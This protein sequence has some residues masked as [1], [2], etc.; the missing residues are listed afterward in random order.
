MPNPSPK[1]KIKDLIEVPAVKT[2]IE[3]ATVRDAA[4]E[5]VSQLIQLIESFVVTADIEKCLCTVLDQIASASPLSKRS[6]LGRG[7][8]GEGGGMGFFLTGSY[9]SGKSHLLSVLS[10]LLQHSWAW[11]SIVAQSESLRDYEARLRER[12]FLVVQIP[13]LEYRQVDTLEDIVWHS[14]E[15]T[16]ASP[17]YGLLTSLAP[18]SATLDLFA[19]YVLPAHRAEIG[20]FL[21]VRYQY[22]GK[23][24]ALRDESPQ[25]ALQYAQEYLRTAGQSVPF[26]LTLD[27]QAAWDKLTKILADYDFDGLA[28][29][30]D[31]LSEFL[32]SKAD[33]RALNEDTRTL[34]FLGERATHF[35]V[36]IVA[37]L[38]EA[39]EKT[40]DISQTTFNKIKDRYP[41]RLE[42]STRHLR[43]L[44]DRRLILKKGE[45]AIQSIRAVYR[46]L[47][48]C[49]Q[50]IQI[51]EEAFIQIYP[52][53]PET[54]ELL[55]VNSRF[56]SQR[57]GVIDFIHCQ[58]RG[59][60]S[61]QT[62]GMLELDADALLTPDK[63]FDH[64]ALRMREQV[65]L[66]PYYD[67]YTTYFDRHIPRIFEDESDRLLA[68]KLIKILILLK[69][70]PIEEKR[71]VRELADMVLFRAIELGGDLN[72]EYIES[73]LARLHAEVGYL[74]VTS[75]LSPTAG[76]GGRGGEAFSDVYELDLE[77]NLIDQVRVKVRDI[78]QGLSENDGRILN[79]VFERIVDGAIPFAHLNGVYSERKNIHWENTLRQG[80]VKLCNLLELSEDEL[81]GTL[82]NLRQTE[83]DFVLY[84]G[85]PFRVNEQREHFQLLIEKVSDRFAHGIICWLP[86][87]IGTAGREGEAPAEQTESLQLLKTFHAYVQLAKDVRNSQANIPTSLS[88][89]N[90]PAPFPTREGG[91]LP[92]PRRGGAGG[93]VGLE[94]VGTSEMQAHLDEWI[95]QHEPQMRTLIEESYFSGKVY[96]AS[97][98]LR[99]DLS[100]WRFLPFNTILERVIQKPLRDLYSQHIAPQ[101]GLDSWRVVSELVDDFVRPGELPRTDGAHQS[102]QNLIESIG[103]PFNLVRKRRKSYQ[104]EIDPSTPVLAQILEPFSDGETLPPSPP[105]R[106]G[107]ERGGAL[108]DYEPLYWQLRKSEF[109]L[110]SPLFDLLLFALIRQGYLIP[111]KSGERVPLS[112]LKL[113]LNRC[114]ELMGKGELISDEY[115]WQLGEVS[116]TLLREEISSYDLSRQEALWNN[117]CKV[118]EQLSRDLTAG[119][120][121]L[122]QLSD[123]LVPTLCVGITADGELTEVLENISRVQRVIA[124]IKP[125]FNSKEGL[126]HFLGA[127]SGWAERKRSGGAEGEAPAEPISTSEGLTDLISK[128]EA[129]K[130]FV[131]TDSER[132]VEIHNYLSSPH[133][134]IPNEP[135]YENLR[136]LK[137]AVDSQLQLNK[138]LIFGGGASEIIEAFQLFRD[139]YAEHYFAEHSRANRVDVAALEQIRLTAGYS[140]LRKLEQIRWLSLPMDCR[141]IDAHIARE[142]GR[143]CNRLSRDDLNRMPACV[144]GFQLGEKVQPLPPPQLLEAIHHSIQGALAILQ[145]SP[146]RERLETYLAQLA[147][148]VERAASPLDNELADR[149]TQGGMAPIEGLIALMV[150]TS[151][152]LETSEVLT[153]AELDR[154]L[155]SETMAH[156]NKALEGGIKMVRRN[157]S[158]LVE[159]LA[160]KQYRKTDLWKV[161]QEWVEEGEDIGE[162]VFVII[163]K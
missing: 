144:C 109:G 52:V 151:E 83:G 163:E 70:S 54:L 39:I 55:D 94:R 14:I 26:K 28:L 88:S 85:V 137:G 110:P 45:P 157:L 22:K 145:D 107:G 102:T 119:R 73:V 3:L 93:E 33:V 43:E 72:Y 103:V 114:V 148:V 143:V 89:P 134:S 98:Q 78:V 27:R 147:Q 40:G 49:F 32:R 64:F 116:R 86:A 37:A 95:A 23:W 57:R 63:I 112:Q 160:G 126:E 46:Q 142:R 120:Q 48:H 53:H 128:A 162:E 6:G 16:L 155:T 135:E 158:V 71:T 133:L 30:I 123:R 97:G 113:P 35:P 111:Y 77:A 108:Q 141:T 10:L 67:I 4:P 36:W 132:L 100:E 8:G 24:E 29:L 105:A 146:H 87:P 84:I 66:S 140:L 81:T 136:E 7:A 38:Q 11:E 129:I 115:R 1:P 154:L 153:Y 118:K 17:R 92:S 104:L 15:R 130:Q 159:A 74:R 106:G 156:L 5:D 149:S 18:D 9:G 44:I 41:Y 42:L 125:S 131:A 101:S 50:H 59:D 69:L 2:V 12:R 99:R 47:K 56:F 31:E 60:P 13:L 20:A 61:R 80:W 161:I 127:V 117:L 91:E 62:P 122:Q 51:G 58:V 21:E 139:T 68:R 138:R 65:D 25:D 82:A 152:V 76:G 75:P 79:T 121:R 34:Q 124:E 90:P 150:K 19:K 96:T